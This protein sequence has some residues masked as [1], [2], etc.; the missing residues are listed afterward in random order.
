MTASCRS[1]FKYLEQFSTSCVKGMC[2]V[3]TVLGIATGGNRSLLRRSKENRDEETGN[4]PT[5]HLTVTTLAKGDKPASFAEYHLIPRSNVEILVG[6]LS[7]QTSSN[8]SSS[9]GRLRFGVEKVWSKP[10]IKFLRLLRSEILRRG[11]RIKFSRERSLPA[12]INVQVTS[13]LASANHQAPLTS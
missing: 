3:M 7:N 13:A 4:V 9:A 5:H 12:P 11:Q 1:L 8:K 10:P 2:K 6:A